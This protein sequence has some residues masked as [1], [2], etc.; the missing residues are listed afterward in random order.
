MNWQFITFW[1]DSTLLL[2]SA[3]L[4]FIMLLYFSTDKKIAWYWGL[5]FGGTSF[6]VCLS[7]L[8]FMGWGIGSKTF[9]FTGFSGHT[10]LSACFYPM[11]FWL[12][13]SRLSLSMRYTAVLIGFIFALGIGFSR[14]QIHAHSI[15]EVILGFLLGMTASII[16]L[17]LQHHA[18]K[19][20]LSYGKILVVIL[21]MAA[22]LST[23][24][25]MPTQSILEKIATTL[26]H[27]EKPYTRMD[28]HIGIISISVS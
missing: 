27:L 17:L 23:E 9:N 4:I 7:K 2:P 28:L 6:V 11:L 12:L 8:A 15:S 10:A 21:F 24:K 13:S 25:K 22:L 14:L 1:G 19:I 3:L 5:L 26:G 16:F 18:P 20:V